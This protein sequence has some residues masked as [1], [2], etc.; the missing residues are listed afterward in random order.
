MKL[1][2]KNMVTIRCKMIVKSV[3]E[4]LGIHCCSVDLGEME[5]DEDITDEQYYKLKTALMTYGLDVL[6]DKK[7]V[8]IE[9]IKEVVIEMVH[10]EDELPKVKN[11]DY[12]STRLHHNYTYLANLFSEVTATTI[13]HYIISHKIERVKELLSYDELSLKEISYKMNY[14]SE[15]HLCNQFRKI[16]GL[17]TQEFKKLGRNRRTVLENVGMISNKNIYEAVA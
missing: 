2:I 6:D 4:S 10:Y 5:I 11:S 15:A 17:T 16:T 7:A 12:I 8:L 13:E 3:S 9:Q 1:F 14:S